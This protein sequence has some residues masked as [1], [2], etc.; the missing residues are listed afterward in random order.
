M[1]FAKATAATLLTFS[2]LSFAPISSAMGTGTQVDSSKD[3]THVNLAASTATSA[4]FATKEACVGTAVAAR[5]DAADAAF[6]AFSSAVS[7][8]MQVRKADL[9]AAYA[10][11]NMKDLKH[12]VNG[13]WSKFRAARK[14]ALAAFKTTRR[15]AWTAFGTARKACGASL[16]ESMSSSVQEAQ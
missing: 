10:S 12:A 3:S 6:T 1:N 2:I 4:S 5:E 15:D 16:V 8:A 11:A 13:A 14:S 9:V 7:A